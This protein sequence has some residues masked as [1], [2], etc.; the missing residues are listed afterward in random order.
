MKELIFLLFLIAFIE[1]IAW[2]FLKK[3]YLTKRVD[4]LSLYIALY[5]SIPYFLIKTLKYEGIGI[6]NL[7]WNILSTIAVLLIGY[8]IFNEKINNYQ[9]IGV[10]LGLISVILLCSEK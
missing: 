7:L 5:I 4:Y 10:G 8:F 2:F 6:V 1:S 9:T 3:H